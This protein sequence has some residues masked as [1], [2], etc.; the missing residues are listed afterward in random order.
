MLNNWKF[1]ASFMCVLLYQAVTFSMLVLPATAAVPGNATMFTVAHSDVTDPVTYNAIG[2]IK[3]V[4]L[5]SR[6][7]PLQTL[8][9]HGNK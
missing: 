1:K 7:S 6:A 8:L 9:A 3:I 4:Q 2:W 5:S